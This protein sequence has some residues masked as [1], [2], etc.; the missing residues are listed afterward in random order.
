M[1]QIQPDNQKIIDSLL[2]RIQQLTYESAAKDAII[3]E[4]Q[5]S[6][7]ESQSETSAE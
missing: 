1:N 2:G 4:L 5:E 7:N 6:Q 3:R